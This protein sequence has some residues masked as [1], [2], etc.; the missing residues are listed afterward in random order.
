MTSNPPHPAIVILFPTAGTG[1][2]GGSRIIKKTTKPKSPARPVQP[3]PSFD[4][5]ALRERVNRLLRQN[6]CNVSNYERGAPY[7]Y[8]SAFLANKNPQRAP[9]IA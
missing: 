1:W 5:R 8:S 6:N 2:I 9:P 3:M 7:L 4:R